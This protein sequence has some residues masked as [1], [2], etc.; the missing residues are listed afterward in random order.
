MNYYPD[1]LVLSSGADKG[2]AEIGALHK[3][4]T[5]GML[6]KLTTIIGCSVGAIIGYL[7]AIGYSPQDIMIFGL[8]LHMFDN[9]TQITKLGIE[10]GVCEHSVILDK[11]TQLTLSKLRRLPTLLDI[12]QEQH[13]HLII[14]AVNINLDTPRITYF[15]YLSHPNMSA[16]EVIKRSI[17]IQPLFPAVDD[18][19]GGMWI[20]GGVIDPFP[21]NLLDDGHHH[22]LG[23]HTEV[24]GGMT[25][26]FIEHMNLVIT[27][28]VDEV[29]RMQIR[30]ISS[31]VKLITVKLKNDTIS[32][33]PTQRLNMYY[34]GYFEGERF[35]AR[36]HEPQTKPKND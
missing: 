5:E 15:D 21:I 16:L 33:D 29:K 20:D 25:S 27:I 36:L 9:K 14:P 11:L 28:L 22:I 7:L 12:F 23:V 35:V 8:G 32:D 1:T 34:E 18:G 26:N 13:I 3:P 31:K 10:F 4:Y 2:M 24:R 17:S 6:S 19:E 30:R